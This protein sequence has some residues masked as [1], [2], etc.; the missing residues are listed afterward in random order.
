MAFHAFLIPDADGSNKLLV[1]SYTHETHRCFM[2]CLVHTAMNFRLLVGLVIY[3]AHVFGDE[4]ARHKT[5][6]HVATRFRKPGIC[7]CLRL[8]NAS[9]PSAAAW[10]TGISQLLRS[11]KF[12]PS[13]ISVAMPPGR[14]RLG[15]VPG[16][17]FLLT[18]RWQTP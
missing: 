9:S 12:L 14:T 3:F 17:L 5:H 8:M 6:E 10:P 7:T 18:R 1:G 16:S 11:L 15:R 2:E 13:V 4:F